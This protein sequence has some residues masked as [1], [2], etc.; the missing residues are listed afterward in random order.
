VR[1]RFDE[2][3]EAQVAAVTFASPDRAAAHRA[4]LDLPFPVLSDVDRSVYRQ[5]QLERTT[6][7]HV[8]NFRTLRLYARLVRQG[9][10]LRRPTEDTRQLGGDFVIDS[11]G[12]LVQGYRPRSPDGRPSVD[13]LLAAVA[14]AA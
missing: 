8:Y 12:V 1:D 7:R 13:Q 4:C 14:R 2:F 10:R 6:W 5:F 11:D 3:G 9:R